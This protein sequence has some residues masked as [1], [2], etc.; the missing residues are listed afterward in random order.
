MELV[1]IPDRLADFLEANLFFTRLTGH[2]LSGEEL[3]KASGVEWEIDAREAIAI[4]R[5]I[6]EKVLVMGMSTGAN[7]GVWLAVTD[8]DKIAGV[9][10]ISPNFGLRSWP[11]CLLESRWGRWLVKPFSGLE[12]SWRPVNS[13]HG[14]YWTTRYPIRALYSMA[15][16]TSKVR[17]MDL[18]RVNQPILIILSS[19]DRIVNT[20]IVKQTFKRFKNGNNRLIYFNRSEDVDHHILGGDIISPAR[21]D[22]ILDEIKTFLNGLSI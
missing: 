21:N 20:R 10:L 7:L 6:G 19:L 2:G 14:Y 22:V 12:R 3:A 13:L 16:L 1:P 9:I 4:G 8:P 11:G 15:E 5:Q 18:E 17:R